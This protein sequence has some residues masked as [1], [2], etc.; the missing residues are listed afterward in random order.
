MGRFRAFR[1][2]QRKKA[3]NV[4]MPFRHIRQ[5]IEPCGG[6]P[7]L[8]RGDEPKL[9][10]GEPPFLTPG[11]RAEQR[12]KAG[13]FQCLAQYVR[14][15][16]ASHV[17]GDGPD[18]ADAHAGG[19]KPEPGDERSRGTRH[20]PA[21]EHEH[22]RDAEG[23]GAVDR[24]ARRIAGIA[25]VEKPHD[26]L[27]DGGVGIVRAASPQ[28]PDSV[29]AHHPRIEVAGGPPGGLGMEARIDV[30]RPAFEPLHPQAA[31]GK[32]PH[33]RDARR[34]LALART[35]RGDAK[36]VECRVSHR[37]FP[38]PVIIPYTSRHT[39]APHTW[40]RRP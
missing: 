40:P 14:M 31:L 17:V 1:R 6:R 21:V 34:G 29:A 36:G 27:A 4:E 38:F 30:V 39:P 15:A 18:E 25:A 3:V 26:A 22:G 37:L 11:Q 20:A 13:A 32:G 5:R 24:T 28:R 19:M 7:G 12:R 2:G 16:G 10:F 33:E 8:F 9:A 35:G 23:A